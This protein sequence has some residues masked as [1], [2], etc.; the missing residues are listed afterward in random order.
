VETD[1]EIYYLIC[2]TPYFEDF[3]LLQCRYENA[4]LPSNTKYRNFHIKYAQFHSNNCLQDKTGDEYQT[5]RK[6]LLKKYVKRP[7][8]LVSNI[9]LLNQLYNLN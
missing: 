2:R 6:Y 4:Q 3:K 9:I 7:L 8:A 5:V 1:S